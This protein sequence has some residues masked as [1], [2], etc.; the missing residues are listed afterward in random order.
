LAQGAP[1]C[2]IDSYVPI[3]RVTIPLLVFQA[4]TSR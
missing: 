1:P 4:K 3:D 2:V